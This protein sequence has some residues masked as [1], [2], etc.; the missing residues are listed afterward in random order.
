MWYNVIYIV[1]S[2]LIL[3]MENT[4]KWVRL[5]DKNEVKQKVIFTS[6]LYHPFSWMNYKN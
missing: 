6:S 3:S 2:L 1:E 4:L 5:V